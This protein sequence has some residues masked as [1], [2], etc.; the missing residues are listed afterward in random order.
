LLHRYPHPI[1]IKKVT[2]NNADFN[3]TEISNLTKRESVVIFTD[4]NGT[5]TNMTNIDSLIAK[6]DVC[7]AEGKGKSFDK[8]IVT[9]TF[10]FPLGGTDGAFTVDATQYA[11]NETAF[12]TMT[13]N[14]ALL[15]FES[16]NIQKFNFRIKGNAQRASGDFTLLYNDLRIKALKMKDN[17][18]V[19]DK[20]KTLTFGTFLIYPDNPLS[21]EEVRRV[22]AEAE[23]DP[24]KSFFNLVWK[25]TMVAALKTA[26]RPENLADK[27][28][29]KQIKKDAERRAEL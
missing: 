14:S 8:G 11:L 6:N 10:T 24:Y 28:L 4:V 22:H 12:N 27:L 23:R 17:E 3:Y 7:V 15:E 13:R 2:F 9:A 29:E 1:D 25:C 5:I 16:F 26:L 18:I 21:G 19:E 20:F